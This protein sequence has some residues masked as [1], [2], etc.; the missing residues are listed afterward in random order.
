MIDAANEYIAETRAVGARA[1]RARRPI[2]SA[3]V[4]FDVAEAVRVAAVLLL[5][6]MPASAAEIL[7]RV[8]EATARRRAPRLDA[9]AWRN[10]GERTI[11]ER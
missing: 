9:A 10:E 8:G 6:V 2:V 7:R 5:P 3:Q 11:A 4:L 1:R